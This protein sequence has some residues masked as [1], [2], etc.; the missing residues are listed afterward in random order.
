MLKLAGPTETH[1]S[2]L[3]MTRAL[4]QKLKH[5][6]VAG[7]MKTAADD[8]ASRVAWSAGGVSLSSPPTSASLMPYNC[9]AADRLPGDPAA[10]YRFTVFS[11][12]F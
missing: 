4:I 7:T 8:G 11:V 10:T 3:A 1:R 9:L 12:R 6:V 5:G 2:P